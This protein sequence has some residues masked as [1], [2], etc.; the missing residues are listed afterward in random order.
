MDF[1]I[2]ELQVFAITK[3]DKKFNY[4]VDQ[5]SNFY[6]LNIKE[7][8]ECDQE[9]DHL[10]NNYSNLKYIYELINCYNYELNT[11][12]YDLLSLFMD[13]ID[14]STQGYI[15]EIEFNDNKS[16]ELKIKKYFHASLNTNDFNKKIL[17]ILDAYKI[18]VPI[19][20]NLRQEKYV[21][22]IEEKF[23][24]QFSPKRLK[25]N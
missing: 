11:N 9:W 5:L 21:P 19:I 10:K 17:Y 6:Q 13:S 14:K 2:N 7:Y 22:F 8:N 16:K 3:N 18:L 1:L 24:D 15:K 23:K 20:E 4:S 12:F 25:L